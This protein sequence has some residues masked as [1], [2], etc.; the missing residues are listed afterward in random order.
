MYKLLIIIL[1]SL[2]INILGNTAQPGFW[3]AGGTG[4]FSLLYPEDSLQY[5]KIQK[6]SQ[7]SFIEGMQ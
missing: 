7:F 6:M 3:G 2:P 4:T 1:F 5:K